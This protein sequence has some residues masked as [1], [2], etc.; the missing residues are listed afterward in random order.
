[1]ERV[2]EYPELLQAKQRLRRIAVRKNV[3]LMV[4]INYKLNGPLTIYFGSQAVLKVLNSTII[5]SLAV[6]ECSGKS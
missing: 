4:N 6:L 2:G 5:R 1:M 3:E